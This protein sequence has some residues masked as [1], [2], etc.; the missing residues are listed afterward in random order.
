[1]YTIHDNETAL[2]YASQEGYCSIAEYLITSGANIN[3]TPL[4]L[5][6][7]MNHELVLQHLIKCEAHINS[8]AKV[9]QLLY[10]LY[11]SLTEHMYNLLFMLSFMHLIYHIVGKF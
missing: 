3:A 8:I 6:A 11:W 5:A 1:M 7:L 4:H 2:H 10:I 9:V